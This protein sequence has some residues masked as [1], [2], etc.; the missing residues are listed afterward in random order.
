LGVVIVGGFRGGGA[1]RH[2]YDV[3]SLLTYS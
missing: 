3:V 1:Q 2:D